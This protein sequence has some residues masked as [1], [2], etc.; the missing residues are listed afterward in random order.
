VLVLGFYDRGNLGDEQY[1]ITIPKYFGK[2][3]EFEFKCVDDVFDVY[4]VQDEDGY[5][6]VLC[7]GGDM[8]NAYFMD[9][10]QIILAEYTGP[11]YAF[12]VGIPYDEEVKYLDLFDHVV[13]R[14]HYDYEL[15]S[16]YLGKKNVSYL[17]DV[18]FN[19][20]TAPH[21]EAANPDLEGALQPNVYNLG[22]C[23]A[24]PIVL[25][26]GMEFVKLLARA[27]VD[28]SVSP[29]L[30]MDT[31]TKTNV[32]NYHFFMFNTDPQN[33]TE[34]DVTAV[35]LMMDELNAIGFDTDARC[36]IH[37]EI[38]TLGDMLTNMSEMSCML[39][40]R[41]HS[42]V[43]S[44]SL[45][46]PMVPFVSTKK[47]DQFLIDLKY[48]TEYV[49]DNMWISANIADGGG[50]EISRKIIDRMMDS[51][52]PPPPPKVQP[53]LSF[54]EL[55]S[56]IS[57]NK[58][59]TLLLEKPQIRN[60]SLDK[61]L[62][63]CMMVLNTYFGTTYITK[64]SMRVPGKM[65][66]FGKDPIQI[67]R[68]I[69]FAV[70]G[71]FDEPSIWGLAE[72]MLMDTF[73]LYDTVI[74][75]YDQWVSEMI[76]LGCDESYDEKYH[77][78][79]LEDLLG[80]GCGGGG[81]GGDNGNDD[82]DDDDPMKSD[83]KNS[84]ESM[85]ADIEAKTNTRLMLSIDPYMDKRFT[86]RV[87]R[88]GWS[89]VTSYL[90]NFDA[91]R[92]MKRPKLIVD[93]YVERT[94]HWGFASLMLSGILPYRTPWVGFIH[95]TFDTI[96]SNHNCT[97]MFE[98]EMFRA[99]LSCCKCLF[100]LSDYLADKIMQA[101]SDLGM[102][103]VRVQVVY[104]PTEFV[105]MTDMFT[106]TKFFKNPDRKV[107]QIGA[108]LRNPYSIYNLPLNKDDLNPLD[109]S[110]AVLKG[111]NMD[112]YF[113][114]D[115]TI[116]DIVEAIDGVMPLLPYY[117]CDDF[118][119]IPQLTKNKYII[120]VEDAITSNHNSVEKLDALCNEEYDAL[121]S[122]NIVFLDLVDCSAANTVI[123]CIVR[124]TILIVNRHPAIEEVIGK[125]YPGFYNSLVEATLILGN[126]KILIQ[127]Y[128]HLSKLNKDKQR[129]KTFLQKFL[130]TMT[131]I[132]LDL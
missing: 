47:M 8:I 53:F 67:A 89:Y 49:V 100:V 77:P 118:N 87:H 112:A 28:T 60:E 99:S 32:V 23:L 128:S 33:M 57:L 40:M 126:P 43:F 121:L 50:A 129:I 78:T 93:T 76:T 56:A 96:H 109:I 64:E 83:Q 74:Y 27:L 69:C 73:V 46:V 101:L 119:Q 108:W 105:C 72:N 11:T 22:I 62:T 30:M 13:V 45:G 110:K 14:S 127:C 1:K 71:N 65:E 81:S 12:S 113:V 48:P 19:Y 115:E 31:T 114:S 88:S 34:S 5:D 125:H 86:S 75:I 24:T 39:C 55:H 7:G 51:D 102:S 68:V 41:Y 36:V 66:T 9:K 122:Q 16:K 4:T 17:P 116:N 2:A 18:A 131:T 123:E 79:I 90:Q 44:A 120:G 58:Y 130:G 85:L 95:H 117:T 38:E 10:V 111:K 94:F 3:F 21:V 20:P 84:L 97:E 106:M 80:Y 98:N 35:K 61:T 52:P 92:F 37:G 70:T 124:N 103:H 91:T 29:R 15:A 107:V 59:R 82:D 25:S 63:S 104:H 54:A 26:M 132:L 42:A 6:F